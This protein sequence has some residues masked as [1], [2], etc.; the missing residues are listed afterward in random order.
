MNQ[1]VHWH[2]FSLCIDNKADFLH[3]RSTRV[4][5]WSPPVLWGQKLIPVLFSNV[6]CF[7]LVQTDVVAW[8]RCSYAVDQ[9]S[10][11]L[12]D[13]SSKFRFGFCHLA[14][15]S[16]S[17]LCIIRYRHHH[18][19]YASTPVHAYVWTRVWC[20]TDDWYKV[21]LPLDGFRSLISHLT[22][23]KVIISRLRR[24][25]SDPVCQLGEQLDTSLYFT[26]RC[27]AT[28]D[29][30]RNYF[31]QIFPLLRPCALKQEH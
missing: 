26:G 18:M 27:V 11:V 2:T 4:S 30:W 20:W 6:F 19:H 28:M 10:F 16:K 1:S 8:R 31:E 24:K 12:T 17:C 15:E 23:H 9:F 3:P 14:A 29:R 25:K 7:L 22:G 13:I 21:F 5:W